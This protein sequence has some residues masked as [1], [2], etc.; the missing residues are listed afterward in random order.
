MTRRQGLIRILGWLG[1]II[2]L[3]IMIFVYLP[4]LGAQEI[5]PLSQVRPGMRGKGNFVFRGN[6]PEEFDFEVRGI[7][8][9]KPNKT[10]V[11]ILS[12]GPKDING[13]EF[14][15]LGKIYR[16]MSGSPLYIDGKII[17]AIASAW[18]SQMTAQAEVTPIEYMISM[19]PEAIIKNKFITWPPVVATIN[20]ANRIRAGQVYTA[21]EVWDADQYCAGY[22]ATVTLIDP[23]RPDIFYAMGHESDVL[24]NIGVVEVPFW[25]GELVTT[26]PSSSSSSTITNKVVPMLGTIIW[27]G[28]FGQVGRLGVFPK[29]MP[30]SIS[31]LDGF[32][33]PVRWDYFFAYT[34]NVSKNLSSIINNRASA[35][36]PPFDIREEVNLDMVGLKP[37]R[38]GDTLDRSVDIETEFPQPASNIGQVAGSILKAS[39]GAVI[40]K[41][42]VS[43]RAVPKR[44][45]IKLKDVLP[46]ARDT[47]RDSQHAEFILT[48]VND[49][50]WKTKVVFDKK[51]MGKP[52]AIASGRELAKKILDAAGKL[53]AETVELLNK[54]PEWDSAYL[55]YAPMQAAA[56]STDETKTRKGVKREKQDATQAN[57]WPGKWQVQPTGPIEVLAKIDPPTPEYRIEGSIDFLISPV[58][59]KNNKKLLGI[60]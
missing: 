37:I 34:P 21:C 26:I 27:S 29:S 1:V 2:C 58:E 4:R 46:E 47:I 30:V 3:L 49:R 11:V 24:G 57:L 39:T 40:S 43:L 5:M 33:A 31:V 36:R 44:K 54:I 56:Y 59:E 32:L 19:R 8:A 48:A 12:G 23:L 52:L 45:I 10:I 6:Q 20:S 55:Y 51:Y 28:Q 35:I 9:A 41:I 53:D 38:Y 42:E 60:F 16:G 14:I 22:D 18:I 50:E 17:G 13:Q 25:L 7:Y 15:N